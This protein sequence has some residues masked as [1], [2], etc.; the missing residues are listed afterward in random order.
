M[1]WLVLAR[2][3]RVWL[4]AMCSYLGLCPERVLVP[5]LSFSLPVWLSD[6]ILNDVWLLGLSLSGLAASPDVPGA[7]RCLLTQTRPRAAAAPRPSSN[8]TVWHC[9]SKNTRL[10]D[11]C[12]VW[13]CH[14]WN[15]QRF[16]LT[17]SG[18]FL[19]CWCIWYIWCIWCIW[20]IAD[21][22]IT[23]ACIWLWYSKCIYV[24]M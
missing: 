7:G 1:S 15:T 23:T 18:P 4:A 24:F 12:T 8:T 20:S 2:L 16:S 6:A 19:L 17:V 22:E 13:H 11:R 9:H 3:M 14:S 10:T 21:R 5:F